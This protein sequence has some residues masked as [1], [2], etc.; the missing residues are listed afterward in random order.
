M[1]LNEISH[2][3]NVTPKKRNTMFK[4]QG[5]IEHSEH[6]YTATVSPRYPKETKAQEDDFNP[7]LYSR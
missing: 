5:N 3:E 1:I 7:I 4:R 2:K 6:R